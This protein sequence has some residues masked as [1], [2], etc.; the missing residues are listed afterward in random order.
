[1]TCLAGRDLIGRM[2]IGD[3]LQIWY[4]LWGKCQP[5]LQGL[6][7]SITNFVKAIVTCG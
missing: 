7:D 5:I 1:M 6:F 2:A 3:P 4:Y